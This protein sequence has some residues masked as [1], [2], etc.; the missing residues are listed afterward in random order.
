MITLMRKNDA[1]H[2]LKLSG[3]LREQLAAD[4][5]ARNR[6]ISNLIRKIL[7]DHYAA[8]AIAGASRPAI[9]AP[10]GERAH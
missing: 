5:A 8:L 3:P 1:Q 7:I 6:S 10:S 9:G 2:C 4:A